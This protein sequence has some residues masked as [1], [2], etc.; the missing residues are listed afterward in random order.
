MNYRSA[1]V[2]F[3]LAWV[4][5]VLLTVIPL[6]IGAQ[7]PTPAPQSVTVQAIA[8]ARNPLPPEQAS[9]GVTKF[10]YLVYGDTRGR[11]DGI[12]LQYEHSLVVDSMLLTIKRLQSTE[13]AVKFVMQTGD[14]V[15]NGGDARHWNTS[16]VG[17]INRLTTEGGIPYFLA[18]G[19]HDVTAAQNLDSPQRQQALRNYLQALSTMI[20]SESASRRLPEY[21]TYAFAYGNTF[22]LALDSNISDDQT[23]FNW[24]KAQLEGLDRK[25]FVNVVVVFHHPPFASGPHGGPR[26]EPQSLGMR[27]RY[28]PLFRA[29]HVKIVF[30]GHDHLFDHWVERYTDES[31]RHRMDLITTAGGGAPLY[32]Y[33]GEPDTSEYVRAYQASRVSLEHLVKPGINPGDNPYHYL[34]VRVD[35]ERM[36]VEVIGVDFGANFSPYRSNK[37][38]LVD[39]DR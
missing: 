35:G 11:R 14:A 26:T 3:V 32:G 1:W 36:D 27:T 5:F 30:T 15:V 6:S 9:A 17:L 4:L 31:G 29:H 33:Q 22:V 23:Q 21:P 16:F 39:V 34:V 2:L 19:N 28:L 18:P 37:A 10:S 8:P 24:A 13:Y 20:P 38:S 25:R 12:D 7:A